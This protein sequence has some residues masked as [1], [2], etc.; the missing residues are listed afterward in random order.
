MFSRKGRE[1]MPKLTEKQ[2]RFCEE[3]LIDLNATQAAKRAGYKNPE[4]G[5]QLITKNN[6]SEY[7]NVLRENQSKRTGITADMVLNELAAIA[8][9]DRTKIA[10]VNADG[11]VELTE[12]D[13]LSP[14]IK[15]AISGIKEGKFG[16][17]VSS[18]D[19]IRALELLGKHLGIFSNGGPDDTKVLEKLDEVLG[20]IKSEF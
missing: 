17:E 15:K 14:E 7:L 13:K 1:V 12:T 19:K 2:K 16:V 20:G 8:F 6:V 4:I 5:R 18:Y 11:V 10:R 9:S 3:Y